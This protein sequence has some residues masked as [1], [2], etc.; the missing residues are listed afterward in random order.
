[1]PTYPFCEKSVQFT[2]CRHAECLRCPKNTY[3][4]QPGMSECIS[5]PSNLN[6][7]FVSAPCHSTHSNPPG[8]QPPPHTA[9]SLF[10]MP[11]SCTS[12][13]QEKTSITDGPGKTS[14]FDCVCERKNTTVNN[15]VNPRGQLVVKPAF[16]C[17]WFLLFPLIERCLCRSW[18]AATTARRAARA[19][20]APTPA[21]AA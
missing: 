8:S 5:C 1:M 15:P 18:T 13:A 11:P 14:L 3:A 9:S 6:D 10:S 2:C 20:L 7:P 19:D 4:D 16:A 17:F 21:R 12:P